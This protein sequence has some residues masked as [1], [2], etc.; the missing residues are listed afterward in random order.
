VKKEKYNNTYKKTTTDDKPTFNKSKKEKCRHCN[1]GFHDED[2]CW[3]KHPEKRPKR[4]FDNKDDLDAKIYAALQ[5]I[6]SAPLN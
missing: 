1:K 5:R 4:G 2:N 3:V 6:V